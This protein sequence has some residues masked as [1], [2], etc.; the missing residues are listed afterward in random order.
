MLYLFAAIFGFGYGGLVAMTSIVVAGL[1]GIGSLGIILG[2]IMF[3]QSVGGFIGPMA[4]G[5]IFD[6]TQSYTP[7]FMVCA[8]LSVIAIML[9]LLLKP[10]SNEGEE[11]E[12]K[13]SARFY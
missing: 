2:F 6:I 7:A 10:I 4:A 3:S 5:R 11:N 9:A 1:F 8:A 12:P 13:R